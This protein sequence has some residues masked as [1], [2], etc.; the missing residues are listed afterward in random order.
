MSKRFAFAGLGGLA[1]LALSGVTAPRVAA[2]DPILTPIIVSEAA[3]IVAKV[4]TP[5]PKNVGTEK[6]EGYVMNANLAQITVRAKGD[7]LGVQTFALT[8]DVSAKMQKIMD[9]GGYQYGDKVT[10]Y[11][12]PQSK[13][14][15]KIKGKPSKAL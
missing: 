10:I 1:L 13:Q 6:F 15:V 14:A 3:P 2:Q 11:Y 8:Q 4:L 7:D 9:K 12:D 5:K